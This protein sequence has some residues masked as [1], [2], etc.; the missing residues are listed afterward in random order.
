LFDGSVSP[1]NGR[2][3]AASL[4]NWAAAPA[5]PTAAQYDSY[6]SFF[7][8]V[9]DTGSHDIL[10]GNGDLDL[11]FAAIASDIVGILATEKIRTV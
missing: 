11:F 5:S 9:R 8:V 3:L 10:N 2:T 4:T 1:K 6:A 7:N